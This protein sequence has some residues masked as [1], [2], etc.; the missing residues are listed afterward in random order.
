MH[1]HYNGKKNVLFDNP[2]G[3]IEH[4]FIVHIK[5]KDA[6]Q[7][8]IHN[9]H[10]LYHYFVR[11]LL[12]VPVDIINKSYMCIVEAT[13]VT[14]SLIKETYPRKDTVAFVFPQVNGLNDNSFP[15]R[16]LTESWNL[17]VKASGS[18]SYHMVES[19]NFV[20]FSRETVNPLMQKIARSRSTSPRKRGACNTSPS[21]KKVSYELDDFKVNTLNPSQKK[22]SNN[23]GLA[24]LL[25]GVTQYKNK[26]VEEASGKKS[27]SRT[28]SI[29]QLREHIGAGN[30]DS[31]SFQQLET[32]KEFLATKI[33]KPLRLLI[34]KIA[35]NRL[36]LLQSSFPEDLETFV[37]RDMHTISLL[38]TDFAGEYHYSLIMEKWEK[39]DTGRCPQCGVEGKYRHKCNE[40]MAGIR[41][42]FK[43]RHSMRPY[44]RDQQEYD[45]QMGK[46]VI[47]SK[48]YHM[49][50]GDIPALWDKCAVLDLET[51]MDQS[52][53]NDEKAWHETKK[54]HKP[55]AL[56][57]YY[58][59]EM[60]I[61]SGPTCVE[62]F[63]DDYIDEEITVI[64][65]NGG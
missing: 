38:W 45:R 2:R 49:K 57:F 44:V 25:R 19:F 12:E 56:G 13:M 11:A 65:F 37:E 28:A 9:V 52:P 36:Y 33:G 29:P 26:L 42:A 27:R 10:I 46:E 50:K 32:A 40:R 22:G 1:K 39:I 53:E 8:P 16:V 60:H 63:F 61:Y 64:T 55:Y 24:C 58:K 62:D 59:E 20:F 34:Y 4:E 23:C 18:D 41:Q 17:S 14:R 3:I 6:F 15:K 7:Y 43:R 54:Y 5:E 47:A 51:F 21:D 30:N 48:E 35:L 31:I